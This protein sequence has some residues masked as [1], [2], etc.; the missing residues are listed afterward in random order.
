MTN[1][2]NIF[3]DA[4]NAAGLSWLFI[5]DNK[6]RNLNVDG[7]MTDVPCVLR[8]F[9][10]EVL[11]LF[12]QLQRVE[13]TMLLYIVHVGFES[14][15][16]EDINENLEEVMNKFIVWREYMKRAGVEVTVNGRPFPQ[17]EQTDYDEYGFVFNLTVKY[18]ICQ[19]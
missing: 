1:F 6:D 13:R 17:W 7:E 15:T 16:S 4:C 10:E 12:D 9:R 14:T 19:S 2:D 11:P 3:N 18:S 5:Y 8:W